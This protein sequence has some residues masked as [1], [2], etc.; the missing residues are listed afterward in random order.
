[1]DKYVI[2]KMVLTEMEIVSSGTKF[3]KPKKKN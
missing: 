1:M 3:Y 2:N